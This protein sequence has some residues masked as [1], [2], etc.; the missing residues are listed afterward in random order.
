M[1]RINFLWILLLTSFQSFSQVSER[2]LKVVEEMPRFPGCEEIEIKS[3]KLKCAE[4]R[5]LRF[6]YSELVYPPNAKKEKIEGMVVTQFFIDEEGQVQEPKIIRDIGGGCGEEALK[7]LN[8]MPNWIPGLQRGERVKV[9]F[10]LPVRFQLNKGNTGKALGDQA[11]IYDFKAREE[12]EKSKLDLKLE[13]GTMFPSLKFYNI[14]DSICELNFSK[15]QLSILRFD[16]KIY[17]E[18]PVGILERE[19]L[20]KLYKKH[21]K[22]GLEICH[23]IFFSQ[24]S[25]DDKSIEIFLKGEKKTINFLKKR[26]SLKWENIYKLSHANY[27]SLRLILGD[28]FLDEN[29]LVDQ[30]GR[31]LLIAPNSIDLKSKVLELLPN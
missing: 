16:S 28:D 23:V 20:N 29:I 1:I 24:V 15:N 17:N 14:K 7:V 25:S 19:R 4:D 9:L 22:S 31:V 8:K 12:F 13:T 10:T 26:E 3:E 2:P 27:E 30:K 6:I 18:N 5:M 21:R 11:H